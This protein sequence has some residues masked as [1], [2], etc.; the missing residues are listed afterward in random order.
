VTSAQGLEVSTAPEG[1]HCARHATVRATATCARC[2]DFAC[3]ACVGMRTPIAVYCNQCAKTNFEAR[4]REH[5]QHEAS[6]QSIGTIYYLVA[7]LYGMG[8]LA[9][10]GTALAK[11]PLIAAM[12]AGLALVFAVLVAALGRG[13]RKLLRVSRTVATV[14]AAIGLLGFPVGTLVNGYILYLLHSK[15][16]NV[17]FSD[18]YKTIIAATP[19]IVYRT[20]RSVVIV[21]GIVLL[22]IAAGLT[23]LIMNQL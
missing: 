11:E 15:K 1:S 20:P 16:G 17:V 8:G 6:V 22:L 4:R 3:G 18:E 10:A 7:G 5:I 9:I 2:G 19:Q 21:L 23:A 12:I 14:L 13:V